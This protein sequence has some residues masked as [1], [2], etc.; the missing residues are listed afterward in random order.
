MSD[1]NQGAVSSRIAIRWPK[2]NS[3][4][5]VV[6]NSQNASSVY[7][8]TELNQPFRRQMT[9][10]GKYKVEL[11]TNES[12]TTIK[13]VLNDCKCLLTGNICHWYANKSTSATFGK[14]TQFSLRHL[15]GSIIVAVQGSFIGL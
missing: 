13:R 10:Y 1:R 5:L 3:I 6:L 15:M 9:I 11:L 2:I 12:M 14:R 8:T 7:L 4:F